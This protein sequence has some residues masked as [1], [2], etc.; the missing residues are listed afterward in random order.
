MSYY[1]FMIFV[2]YSIFFYVISILPP[3]FSLQLM[4][5][6]ITFISE[7]PKFQPL[8]IEESSFYPVFHFLPLFFHRFYGV[9]LRHESPGL[10]CLSSTRGPPLQRV[11]ITISHQHTCKTRY[12]GDLSNVMALA[13]PILGGITLLLVRITRAMKRITAQPL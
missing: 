7:T 2:R 11:D 8:C 6:C 13:A 9:H 3:R 1:E 10:N 4:I 5:R 12:T